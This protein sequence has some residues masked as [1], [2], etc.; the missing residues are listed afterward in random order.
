MSSSGSVVLEK[1]LRLIPPYFCILW[2]SPLGKEPDPSREQSSIL[3]TQGWFVPSL[4]EI[5]MLVL[6]KKIVFNVNI[7]GFPYHAYCGPSR[8]PGTMVCRNLNLHYVKKLS[9]KYE[10]IWLCGSWE[11]NFYMTP[12][13]F[14]ILSFTCCVYW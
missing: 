13:H 3:F 10:L 9:C 1:I 12:P 4:I 8:L 14:C 7:Y 5:G 2:L 11:E 6:E